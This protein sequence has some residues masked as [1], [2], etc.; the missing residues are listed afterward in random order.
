MRLHTGWA[1]SDTSLPL[2]VGS[3]RSTTQPCTYVGLSILSVLCQSISHCTHLR[4]TRVETQCVAG[5]PGDSP[6]ASSNSGPRWKVKRGSGNS[7]R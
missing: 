6:T 1:G 7:L 2:K 5:M 4:E 3:V